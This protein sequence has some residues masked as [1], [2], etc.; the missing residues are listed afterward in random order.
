MLGQLFKILRRPAAP[1]PAAPARLNLGC[2]DRL[3]P[4]YLN[5]DKYGQPDL[6]W[7]LEIFPWPWRDDSVEHVVM[8]HVLEHLGATPDLFMGIMRELYRVCRDGAKL[9]IAVPHPRHDNFLGDPTHVRPITLQ[10]LA[11]FSRT[12]NLEW[13]AQGY[14]NTPLALYHDI[15]FE[16][17]E[18]TYVLEEEYAR[19]LR[20]SGGG[21]QEMERLLRTYNNVASEINVV[22]RVVKSRP[23]S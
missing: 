11:L 10:L 17:E 23:P 14:A 15:D 4:G 21:P 13:Q 6:R 8:S 22:M 5:V 18:S 1:A 20:E 19:R 3:L 16:I 7:D 12:R 2:G 9:N